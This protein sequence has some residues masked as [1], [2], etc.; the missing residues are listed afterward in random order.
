[1]KAGEEGVVAVDRGA[2]YSFIFWYFF[3]AIEI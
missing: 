2:I 1:M 3:K